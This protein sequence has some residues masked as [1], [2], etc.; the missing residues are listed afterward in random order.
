MGGS[1]RLGEWGWQGSPGP[2][3]KPSWSRWEEGL[4]RGW[5]REGIPGDGPPREGITRGVGLTKETSAKPRK[6]EG[7]PGQWG[8]GNGAGVRPG[9]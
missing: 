2:N 4:V 9:G 7:I 3:P 8:E 1:D 5:S 6:A